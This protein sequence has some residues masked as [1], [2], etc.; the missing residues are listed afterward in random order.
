MMT[1]CIVAIVIS[2]FSVSVWADYDVQ[3]MPQGL[4]NFTFPE[5]QVD[6][7]ADALTSLHSYGY[8]ASF[9]KATGSEDGKI[10]TY[11]IPKDS[12]DFQGKEVK[13]FYSD[14]KDPTYIG[15]YDT[16]MGVASG[17]YDD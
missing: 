1:R 13:T 6:T 2:I 12:M 4:G 14:L 15:N 11:T 9:L 10:I 8:L 16:P 5:D 17:D 7:L 3:L